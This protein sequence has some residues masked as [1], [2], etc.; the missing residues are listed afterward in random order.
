MLT[1]TKP[2]ESQ[3]PI[4]DTLVDGEAWK[5]K[6]F[7]QLLNISIGFLGIQ[8][9]WAVQMGQMSPLL[10]RLGSN[11]Q[12]LGLISCAGP[13]T[14][15]LIQPIV[16]ALSD[17]CTLGMGRRR[18]FLLLGAIMTAIALVAMP[19]SNGLLM[20]AIL[21]WILDAGINL[22]QGPYRALVPDVVHKT[23][24]AT[25]YSL[26][27][28]TIGLGSVAAFLIAFA[29]PSLHNLFYIGASA[30]LLAMIW[31]SVTTPEPKPAPSVKNQLETEDNFLTGT[32]KSITSMPK[33]GLKLCIAHMFTWFGLMCLF[34]FFS[35]YVPHHI[36]GVTDTH[37][38]RYAEGVQWASLCY[39]M[40]N[41]VCFI[42]SAF[43]GKLCN[44]TSKKWVHGFG[45]LC[46]AASFGL[47]Y[48]LAATGSHASTGIYQVQ[49][50]TLLTQA[51]M[52]VLSMPIVQ[53]ALMMGMIG[54][55]WATTLSIPFA[56]LSDHLPAGKEGVMM[57]TF[58]IFIAAPGVLSNLLVGQIV[59][60][61]GD[62]VSVAMLVG[63]ASMLVSL[64]LLQ[65]VKEGTTKPENVAL[66]IEDTAAPV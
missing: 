44:A 64:L 4:L 37:S 11:P 31:T 52:T 10:E 45:L 46:M 19:N 24:Q 42:F 13:V 50:W 5:K 12:L 55:G 65:V 49:W 3:A 21:L 18:P 2:A 39:A 62:N 36:F 40:L 8:F 17:K 59:H 58:N 29:I 54:I 47:M 35:V 15:V 9:A 51:P 63:G 6:S 28:L 32:L 41:G 14:G 30:M 48:A 43:I 25:A 22:T 66:A 26:M 56:L 34:T 33:E 16:G 23:Q 61:Y 20:A 60:A 7:L 27:S 38:L 53:V 1:A 57:G